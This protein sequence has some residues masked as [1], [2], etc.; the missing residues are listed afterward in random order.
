MG[1][2]G[3]WR[4]EPKGNGGKEAGGSLEGSG[5]R[6]P[7]LCHQPRHMR[8]NRGEQ[9]PQGPLVFPLRLQLLLGQRKGWGLGNTLKMVGVSG[10]FTAQPRS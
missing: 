3:V 5:D 6:A 7:Q 4:K 9:H 2:K 8:Q 10:L 1:W